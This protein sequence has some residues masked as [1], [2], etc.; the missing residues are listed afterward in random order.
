[1]NI[2][3][4][5]ATRLS[6]GKAFYPVFF[7]GVTNLL[8]SSEFRYDSNNELVTMEM[9]WSSSPPSSKGCVGAYLLNDKVFW[10][11]SDCKCCAYLICEVA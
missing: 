9:P 7:I 5:E 1:M 4:K 6:I 3:L 11:S 2:V 8:S 10:V